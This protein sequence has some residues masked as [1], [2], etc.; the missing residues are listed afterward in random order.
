MKFFYDP[1]IWGNRIT[2]YP[3]NYKITNNGDGTVTITDAHGNIIVDG[4]PINYANLSKI[5]IAIS[6]LYHEIDELKGDIS[7]QTNNIMDLNFELRMI[8]NSNLSG[9]NN[10]IYTYN[11]SNTD[12]IIILKG[13]YDETNHRVTI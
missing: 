2:Q 4:T 9:A 3:S 5:D 1:T 8:K 12:D 13:K 10:K 6:K 7:S 11:L